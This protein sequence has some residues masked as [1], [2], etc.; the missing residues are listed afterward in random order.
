LESHGK[1]LLVFCTHTV[2]GTRYQVQVSWLNIIEYMTKYHRMFKLE[3][4]SN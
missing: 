4:S 3:L 2:P 1:P